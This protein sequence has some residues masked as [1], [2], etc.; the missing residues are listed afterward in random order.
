MDWQGYMRNWFDETASNTWQNV[1]HL[2]EDKV[3]GVSIY[4]SHRGSLG[5]GEGREAG[6]G[7]AD[8]QVAY[9]AGVRSL[10]LFDFERLM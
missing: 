3:N 10:N 6:T 9:G 5:G 1:K 8:G 7:L 2:A 4:R